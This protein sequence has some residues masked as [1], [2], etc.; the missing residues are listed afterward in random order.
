[1]AEKKEYA[2]FRALLRRAMGG[3]T[4][5]AFADESGISVEHL[6][7]MLNN[8][9]ISR[10]SKTTLRKIL[11]VATD[12]NPYDLYDACDYERIETRSGVRIARYQL[13][14][15]ERLTRMAEDLRDSFRRMIQDAVPFVTFD[16]AMSVYRA[17]Y[18]LN[19][20]DIRYDFNRRTVNPTHYKGEFVLPCIARWQTDKDTRQCYDVRTYFALFGIETKNGSIMLTDVAVDAKT[21]MDLGYLP[22]TCVD[23]LYEDGTNVN[24]LPYF[25]VVTVKNKKPSV[26]QK[27]LDAI[28]GQAEVDEDG[29]DLRRDLYHIEWGV[30]SV[31]E[32]TPSGFQEYLL[33][34]HDYFCLNAES[35]ELWEDVYDRNVKQDKP[36]TVEELDERFHD[37]SFGGVSGTPAAVLCILSHKYELC[38]AKD[39]K[40]EVEFGVS[41]DHT[42]LLKPVL[43]VPE[44]CWCVGAKVDREKQAEIEA[45]FY[46]EMKELG[47]PTFGSTC[48]YTMLKLSPREL[49]GGQVPI[50]EYQLRTAEETKQMVEN[51]KAVLAE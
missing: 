16:T 8:D 25:S 43:F 38:D 26:E 33:K 9:L 31:W 14:F 24:E 5:K 51:A 11:A 45:I 46:E 36:M 30:G 34:H 44:D 2:E 42:D 18:T 50:E 7:R 10:P 49:V 47:M 40:F 28:F 1:M 13:P 39:Y 41:E 15:E 21:L 27:L 17:R 20:R 48:C 35:I 12:I 23:A 37:Y 22:Q 3:M 19:V 4:Q 29:H 6:N 32:Q